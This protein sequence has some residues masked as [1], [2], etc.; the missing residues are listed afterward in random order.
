MADSSRDPALLVHRVDHVTRTGNVAGT[1]GSR[2]VQLRQDYQDI[3]P[4]KGCGI[5]SLI[6]LPGS[7]LRHCTVASYRAVPLHAAGQAHVG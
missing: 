6:L 2:I 1:K 4:A 3:S 5:P 7:Q